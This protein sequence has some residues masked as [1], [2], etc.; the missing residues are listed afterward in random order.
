MNSESN[1]PKL[2][3]LREKHSA[4]RYLSYSFEKEG[5]NLKLTYAFLLEPGYKFSPKIYIPLEEEYYVKDNISQPLFERMVFLIGMVEL[6]SYWK[7]ACSKQISIECGQLSDYELAWWKDLYRNGLGEFYYVNGISPQLD[8]TISIKNSSI[9]NE[10][11]PLASKNSPE[12]LESLEKK[13]NEESLIALV[14]GGKDSIVTLEYAKS[15]FS[16]TE[17]RSRD[18]RLFALCVNPIPAS[19]EAI[20]LAGYQNQI[21]IKRSIDPLLL[22]L[23]SKGYLNGHTPFSA[24]LSFVSVLAALLYNVKSVLA[25]NESSASEGNLIYEGLE[26]NHQYSKSYT[27]E[28]VF[29][30]YMNYLTTPVQYYSALRPLNEIQIAGLFSQLKKYHQT[31]RSCN[32]TQTRESQKSGHAHTWC[33]ACPKCL[34]TFLTLACFLELDELVHIF[35]D[36]IP[37]KLENKELIRDLLGVGLHKPLECVGTAEEVKAGLLSFYSSLRK[38]QDM[39]SETEYVEKELLTNLSKDSGFLQHLSEWNENSFVPENL[40]EVL[41]RACRTILN[42]HSNRIEEAG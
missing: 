33:G 1:N 6:I 40:K 29:R 14:G 18:N 15:V 24:F 16:E 34:F 42:E 32:K 17:T 36:L 12:S 31:F 10:S 21:I 11:T 27:Y 9:L 26:V 30:E 37:L 8:F 28:K 13:G 3:S 25:S 4:I 35:G 20:Q 19:L 39:H 22:E 5:T 23:N 2:D 41:K 38:N 7:L